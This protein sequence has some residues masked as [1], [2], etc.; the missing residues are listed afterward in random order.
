[1]A[2]RSA[3]WRALS[4]Q[5]L[6]NGLR[7]NGGAVGERERCVRLGTGP[8]NAVG[9]EVDPDDGRGLGRVIDER[10]ELARGVRVAQVHPDGGGIAAAAD[11]EN[12]VR[13]RHGGVGDARLDPVLAVGGVRVADVV[14]V[15]AEVPHLEEVVGGVEPDAVGERKGV[16]VVVLPLREGGEDGIAGI[17]HGLMRDAREVGLCDQEI[18]DEELAAE[19]DGD[20]GG[21][22][23]DVWRSAGN[24]ARAVLR[25]PRQGQL[26]AV[27]EHL[28]AGGR[29]GGIGIRG[30]LV[31]VVGV[32][33]R[34]SDG[35]YGDGRGAGD[36]G[37]RV[38]CGEGVGGGRCG[39]DG[40]RA[41]GGDGADALVDGQ[42]V[43]F[44]VVQER[45][46]PAAVKVVMV[47]AA[48]EM[49]TVDGAGDGG[50]RVGCGEGVGGGRC[51]ADGG[52]AGGG[53]GADALVDGHGGGVCGGPGEGGSGGGEG[54]DGRSGRD[55]EVAVRV[56][57]AV[58]LD[59]VRV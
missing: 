11:L 33:R 7:K 38:G 13:V 56:T 24:L 25:W 31:R 34:G 50:C 17:H 43:A 36:G 3:F 8:V 47:G 4:T 21:R 22:I 26:D 41:G 19:V 28:A 12:H 9:R 23:A 2:G 14:A 39:G 29:L 55:G 27:V 48:A 52:R 53:D 49:L 54:G 44:A 20:D 51:G 45:V 6:R 30:P 1:M 46:V 57:E 58:A 10:L 32:G 40:G 16:V 15:A 37:G 18:V 42:V 5:T 59:A 35:V